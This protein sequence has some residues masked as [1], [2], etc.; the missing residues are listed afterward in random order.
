[1][2]ESWPRHSSCVASVRIGISRAD[3]Y[4]DE[5]VLSVI[6]GTVTEN[7][8]PGTDGSVM[9]TSQDAAS[10]SIGITASGSAAEVYTRYSGRWCSLRNEKRPSGCTCAC[11]V[12]RPA[13]LRNR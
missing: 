1:M 8:T 3:P 13:A 4:T 7:D 11:S 10:G 12:M 9:L 5:P 6:D 2:I